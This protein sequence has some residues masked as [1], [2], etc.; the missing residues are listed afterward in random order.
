MFLFASFFPI[1]AQTWG[2]ATATGT[3]TQRMGHVMESWPSTWPKRCAAAPT[4][5]VVRGTNLVNSVLFPALVRSHANVYPCRKYKKLKTTFDMFIFCV[6]SDEFGVLCGSERPG[7]YID[8]TT[9]RVIG[10]IFLFNSLFDQIEGFLFDLCF[11]LISS[12]CDRYW[13]VQG[14]PRSVW[15]WSVHQ[16]D[17]QL[18]VRVP[19][20]LLLQ[21]Q[22]ADLWR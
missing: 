9:G 16:H 15:E 5:L 20:W 13:W 18:Q 4:T 11:N 21:R 6:H 22:A 10:K 2:R 8:I 19:H 12:S 17:W 3:F 14:N 1:N 7:Y